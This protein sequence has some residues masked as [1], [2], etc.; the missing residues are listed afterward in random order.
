MA[1]VPAIK[2]GHGFGSTEFHV[3]R[4]FAGVE[5]KY[6][7]YFVSSE[8]FRAAAEHNMTGAVGQRRVPAPYLSEQR[9]PIAPSAEQRR[10]VGK[11]EDLFSEL[12]KGV[13]ALTTAREQLKGYRQSAL[14][15]TFEGKL[16]EDWR[17]QRNSE[18]VSSVDLRARLA[19]ERQAYH[20]R[21]VRD[22]TGRVQKWEVAGSKGP[23]PSRVR[24]LQSINPLSQD[25][26]D[27]LPWLPEGWVWER[28]AWMTCGV[29]YGT[30][31]KSAKVGAV[32][33]IRMG[34]LQ[35]GRIDLVRLGIH[36][37]S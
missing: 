6:I 16:T 11:V 28:L 20:Q 2:N 1:I 34:N 14:K 30:A 18:L 36:E 9:I 21:L 12:D 8:R 22:W 37:R 4:P 13:E 29:D 15:H 35:N 10:I 24:V 32:P 17:K 5:A 27:E 33:V 3:L 19:M 23:K 7:Y 31:A 26:L 25:V